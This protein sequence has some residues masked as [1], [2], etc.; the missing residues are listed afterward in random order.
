MNAAIDLVSLDELVTTYGDLQG[1]VLLRHAK[2]CAAHVVLRF[3]PGE[4]ARQQV[5]EWL[6]ETVA[7]RLTRTIDQ[8]ID[9]DPIRFPTPYPVLVSLLLTASG[10]QQLGYE[11]PADKAFR[12]GMHQRALNDPPVNS[13]EEGF[14][15]PAQVHA[16]LLVAADEA[17]TVQAT[18][19]ALRPPA[20][21]V[22]VLTVAWGHELPGGIEHFGFVDGISQPLYI[23]EEWERYCQRQPSGEL[24]WNPATRLDQILV[25]DALSAG[26]QGFGSYLVFRKLAQDVPRFAAN[27]GRLAAT[28][29]VAEATVEAWAVGR[30]KDGTPVSEAAAAG[31][32]PVNDFSYAD[33]PVGSRCPFHAHIRKVNPRGEHDSLAAT[34]DTENRIAR[35]SIPYG[36]VGDPDVGMLFMCFQSNLIRQFELIQINWSNFADFGRLR[37]GADPVSGQGNSW[38][39][40][41]HPHWPRQW[42]QPERLQHPWEQCVTMRGG[43]YF[44]APSPSFLASLA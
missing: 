4:A 8:L 34:A 35:R 20:A 9:I 30:F 17:A 15:D 5:A 16:L 13:W 14:T 18:L 1:N 31:L 42:G 36:A 12:Q 7:P 3:A 29:D 2:Q 22:E 25:P 37:A 39:R 40:N 38:E 6:R 43:A 11:A 24:R 23:R 26:G 27:V 21:A 28:L 10:Y 44:F 33:D 32:G 41:K 19:A